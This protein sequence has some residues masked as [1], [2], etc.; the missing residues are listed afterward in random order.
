MQ[1]PPRTLWSEALWEEK[2]KAEEKYEKEFEEYKKSIGYDDLPKE[3]QLTELM[4]YPI[5]HMMNYGSISRKI[6]K[7]EQLSDEDIKKHE[8]LLIKK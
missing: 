2:R 6:F 1:D 3:K 8:H 5:K 7:V 4:V